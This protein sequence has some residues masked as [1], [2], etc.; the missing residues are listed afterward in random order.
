[1][2]KK[3]GT[4]CQPG[5]RNLLEASGL[6]LA[7][8]QTKRTNQHKL[9]DLSEATFERGYHHGGTLFLFHT[10]PAAWSSDCLGNQLA[11]SLEPLWANL[12]FSGLPVHRLC[13]FVL[14]SNVIGELKEKQKKCRCKK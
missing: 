9:P 7:D 12:V 6:C 1:M 4:S 5:T 2:L 11:S 14:F 13:F 3:V 10:L 8:K